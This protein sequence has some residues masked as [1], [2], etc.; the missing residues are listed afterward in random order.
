MVTDPHL[1]TLTTLDPRS[2]RALRS[3]QPSWF[4][5]PPLTVLILK[6][7]IADCDLAVM[8]LFII[9]LRFL[10]LL[11]RCRDS[12]SGDHP[13]NSSLSS[14]FPLDF[15]LHSRPLLPCWPRSV[16]KTTPWC[17]SFTIIR[18]IFSPLS[19]VNCTN[20]LYEACIN[21]I[22]KSN[23]YASI[24][25][26]LKKY[27]H[28]P[29]II[30]SRRWHGSQNI[31]IFRP[32]MIFWSEGWSDGRFSQSI[33]SSLNFELLL[34]I[35]GA[36]MVGGAVLSSHTRISNRMPINYWPIMAD[37]RVQCGELQV[38]RDWSHSPFLVSSVSSI[39]VQCP[40]SPIYLPHS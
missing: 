11:G 31:R 23:K 33:S 34:T 13:L 10:K 35:E 20:W 8:N 5:S 32:P 22:L 16:C 15:T 38:P 18:I 28:V 24:P 12:F 9:F 39:W 1:S 37:Q 19:Q 30:F 14:L 4:S 21:K 29:K 7:Y 26:A 25:W 27:Q 17:H 3:L 36:K 2:L 6:T 40:C